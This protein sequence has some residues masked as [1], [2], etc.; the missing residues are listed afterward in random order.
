LALRDRLALPPFATPFWLFPLRAWLSV[1]EVVA[2]FLI[3]EV[4][5]RGHKL[6]ASGV[7]MQPAHGGPSTPG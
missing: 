3:N 7:A 6:A 1:V 2:S 5:W 4:M